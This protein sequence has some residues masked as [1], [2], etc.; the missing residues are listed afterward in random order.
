MDKTTLPRKLTLGGS[1]FRERWL[2]RLISIIIVFSVWEIFGRSYHL[3]FAP[4]SEIAIA[5]YH[6][7][8]TGE[9]GKNFL[10]SIQHMLLGL[11]LGIALGIGLGL[12]M[13]AS[14]KL[15]IALDPYILAI[16]SVPTSGLIPL[17]MIWF[18]L[19][20]QAKVVVVFLYTFFPI[21]IN[22]ISGV[23]NVDQHALETAL[24]FGAS[25]REVF[26]K[27]YLPGSVPYIVAGV[28]QGLGR[29]V[30]GMT[31]AEILLA[32]IGLGGMIENA[33]GI[34]DTATLFAV[35]FVLMCLGISLTEVVKYLEKRVAPWKTR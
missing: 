12:T 3:I 29:A 14:K 10:V 33:M 21:L 35:L 13:G 16:F 25:K 11:G 18:G 30:L 34:F 15:E 7:T 4:P 1:S 31:V 28:R 23:R 22:T 19:S 5:L 17:I 27:I 32:G 24:S 8:V 6:I 2:I 26:S 9:L 20:F